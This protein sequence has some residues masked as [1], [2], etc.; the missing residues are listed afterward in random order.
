MIQIR[1][2]TLNDWQGICQVHDRSRPLEFEETQNKREFTPLDKDPD[3]VALQQCRL[4]VACEGD[5][6]IG[7]SG[8][9]EDYLGWLYLDPEYRGRGIARQLLQESLKYTGPHTWTVTLAE[10]KNALK[11]YESEGFKVTTSFLSEEEGYPC[12]VFKL[13]RD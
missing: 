12:Q 13:K 5:K 1:P 4:L 8:S 7:F 6:V 9:H 11:F 2:Y 10:N 3:S